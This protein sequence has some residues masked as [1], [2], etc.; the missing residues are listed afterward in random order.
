MIIFRTVN[1]KIKKYKSTKRLL[2]Y[3]N[4]CIYKELVGIKN[5]S[6]G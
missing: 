2:I 4:K 6:L 3:F 5:I 1:F